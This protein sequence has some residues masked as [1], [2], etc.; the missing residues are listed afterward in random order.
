MTR[1]PFLELA[2]SYFE[3][4]AEIDAAISA[5]LSNG[6]YILGQE[7]TL[8]ERE[9]A[10]YVCAKHC[11]GVGNGLDALVLSLMAYE[12]GP[13]D[14]VIV[15]SNTYVATALAVTRVGA[16][17]VFVEP[18]PET[19]NLDP[20][21]LEAA[22]TKRTAAV[23]PVHL[24][25]LPVNMDPIVALSHK[26]GFRVIEDSAQAHG[27]KYKNRPTG[28]LGDIAAF[29]FYPSKCL[30]AFGDAG[31]VVTNDD[32]VADKIRLIRNYGSRAKYFNDYKGMNSRLDELQAAILRIKLRHLDEWNRR[33]R[34]LADQLRDA[35]SE[36]SDITLPF[37]PAEYNSCWHLFVIR[38]PQRDYV[39][40]A[41]KVAGIETSIHYPVP[42]Y[43]QKAYADLGLPRGSFPIAD[44]LADE[45]LSLP[46]GPHFTDHNWIPRLRDTLGKVLGRE[47]SA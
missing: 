3:L 4:K 42:P 2:P 30:G 5:V 35:L 7:V 19:H 22:I 26:Y 13:G 16:K 41:L 28:S 46:M 32:A 45:V 10:Q 20:C 27:S 18:D 12:V 40:Q 21:R 9:F 25:G 38:T 1:I 37:E 23:I 34:A 36:I 39:Q 24:Y 15:P 29:S 17:L 14:E 43:R 33:R 6:W 44:Q 8:F 11:V 31:A 47:V